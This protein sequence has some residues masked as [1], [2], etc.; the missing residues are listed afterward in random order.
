MST[1]VL[2]GCYYLSSLATSSNPR[3]TS[4]LA[5]SSSR[6]YRNPISSNSSPLPSVS[7]TP[8]LIRN[9]PVLATPSTLTTAVEMASVDRLKSGFEQFK[10]EV[11]EKK[12]EVFNQ[13]AE[14]QS[15]KFLIFACSDSRVCPSVLFNFQP[16]EAFTIRNIANMVP[17]YD[18][19]R[20]SGIGAAVEYPVVHLKVENIIVI[21]HSRCGGIKALLSIK[22]NASL[23][24][25]FIEDWVKIC[26]PAKEA[27]NQA[28]SDLSFEEQCSK[29][30]KEAVKV[31]LENLKTYPYVKEG[32]E[33]KTLALYG[34]YYD[35]VN[36]A[37]ETWEPEM[38]SVDRL[39][40]GFEQFKKE[41]Y[42]KKPE[43]FN[44]LA[45]GQSPK[46]LVFACSDS[47]V[48]PS[49][50]FNFQ[51]G[52]AFT[53]RN[54]AN[55]VPPYD[56]TRYS[57]IGAAVEYPI[58]HLKVEN[59]IVIGHS[60]CG[61]IKALL[62]T[63]DNASLGT[64]FIEDWVK[65]CT[66][67]KEAVNQAHGDLSFEEQCSKLEKEAVKVSLENL[68]TYPYVKEGL[69][70]KTLAL[71]GGY[72]DF[73]NGSFETWEK[74]Q[75]IHMMLAAH[76]H[77]GTKNCHFQMERYV[78]K[79]R[80]DGIYIIN[81]GKTWEK[82]Q[83]AARVIVAIENPQD[84][85]VQS[86]RPY[87]QRAVLKFAQYTGAHPIAGRHTPG[88]FTNQ[89]QTSFSEPR[90]LILA[91][92]RTDHQPIRES[93]LGNIPTIAFCDTDSQLRFIDIGIP[94]NNKG[95]HSIGCL[96]WLLARMVLQMR[97]TIAPGHKWN[98]MVD[99]FFHRDPEEAKEQQEEG[100]ASVAP[101][102]GAVIEY[103]GIMPSEQWPS[104]F[105]NVA[106]DV[107]AMPSLVAPTTGVE[108]TSFQAD[109]DA[110]A[111]P[112]AESELPPAGEMESAQRLKSGFE[113]FKKEVYEKEPEVFSQLAEGQSPKF[114]VFACSDSRVCPSVL[115]NFQPGEAFTIRNIANIVPSY[116][117]KRYSGIGAAI[118]YP[119]VH[120]KVENIIVMGHSRC[121]GIKALLSIKDDG[122]TGTD[123]IEDWVKICTPAKERVKQAHG[124][125]SFEEQCS[126][127]EKE[128]VKVSLENLKTYP[129]V[130][131]GL[132]KK[133][134]ALYGGYYDFVNGAFET[135]EA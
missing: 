110:A 39:K 103:G 124:D 23:G 13:L 41:V 6:S 12:P 94:G 89:L 24:T 31:S 113:R 45:E 47:R 115:F 1:A 55:M 95:K 26:T 58:V 116:D 117:K 83:L 69:E 66:P 7:S 74:E 22:D 43:V 88:T 100:E 17:P 59:V 72:Y 128:A 85:I 122:T 135:W 79:R 8:R 98:V 54:I 93:A 111:A 120:L 68:K 105:A 75:D 114:L 71:Y 49:V 97:G 21:G 11:Y 99:L 57:G 118:E 70:K 56:K 9:A 108:W 14:G 127:C 101:N 2:N 32:L 64:D 91:D 48:C 15:P 96:F 36:G 67:A 82:M 3:S 126:K 92:P 123:F 112:V 34:G 40:S 46:F 63:K 65:I 44:Q 33:K 90:L 131:E 62:S 106:L 76:V 132:E 80:T 107:E 16:G 5:S 77:L 109:W 50:L 37:F 10:K 52:E 87:G 28:H 121:G 27:V 130:K 53:I 19:T 125:L 35:F 133:T 38:A 84:I 4:I 104:D 78:F 18:K 42:E 119:V 86:A 81:I 29:L 51:P 61:G 30:E 73:V 134:L 129:Y 25:D 102:Y 60:R 20:Y